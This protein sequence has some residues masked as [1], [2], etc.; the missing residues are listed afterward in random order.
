[1]AQD[2]IGRRAVVARVRRK[3]QRHRAVLT[4]NIERHQADKVM[5]SEEEVVVVGDG[6]DMMRS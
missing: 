1:M 6:N 4:A 3:Q 5:R 2:A